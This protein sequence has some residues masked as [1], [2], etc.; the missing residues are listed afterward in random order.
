[1]MDPG[2]ED[3]IAEHEALLQFLYL[4]PVGLV[5]TSL[6]GD[7][8]LINPLSAQL[9]MPI[10]MDGGLSNLFVVLESVAPELR[11]MS[12]NFIPASGTICESFR[13]QLNAGIRGSQDP[14]ILGVTLIK[15]DAHRLM[16]VLTDMTQTIA[17]ERQIKHSAAWV[18][19]ITTGVADYALI[20]LDREG[21]IESWNSSIG[22]VTGFTAGAVLD[23][24]FSLFYP[25][26]GI[27]PERM[28]DYLKEADE[29]GWS[30]DEGW[31]I[32]ADGSTFWGSSMIAPIGEVIIAADILP[33]DQDRQGYAFILRDITDRHTGAAAYLRAMLSDYLTGLSNRRA[34]FEAADLELKRWHRQPRPLSLIV[35]DADFFKKINDTY[36][37]AAGD[38]VL[39][40]LALI[41]KD[42]VRFIDT[43]ARI[44]GEEFAA[45]LPS[46]DIEGALIMAERFRQRVANQ[47]VCVDGTDIRYTVS[48]G[49]SSMDKSVTGFDDLLQRADKALYDAKHAGRNRVAVAGNPAA[50]LCQLATS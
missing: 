26:G 39:Q 42:S 31:R 19:A 33:V 32:K 8:E 14:K 4:A 29:D 41:L 46:T 18:N 7:V 10:S 1:M 38:L 5:Q 48:I 30:L 43:V 49:I 3:F 22:R 28:V 17:Q 34:F 21:R 9:L 37:H 2:S 24:D 36:G 40:D 16:A 23:Q 6:N 12:A 47:R 15:L 50:P 45:L 20:S 35:I 13:V 44:G 25:E 27:S 11:H